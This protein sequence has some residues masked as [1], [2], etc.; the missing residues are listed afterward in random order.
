[1]D[2]DLEQDKNF[3]IIPLRIEILEVLGL[4]YN[5]FALNQ[6]VMKDICYSKGNCS[7]LNLVLRTAL[8]AWHIPHSPMKFVRM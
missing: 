5:F 1:M 2:T 7:V 8:Y 6:Y 4:D 3:L